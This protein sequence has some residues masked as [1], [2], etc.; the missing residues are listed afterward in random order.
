MPWALHTYI[1]KTHLIKEW[2]VSLSDLNN[3]NIITI[4]AGKYTSCFGF[5]EEEVF[6][7][8]DE[9]G[10]TN[11][12]EVKKWYDDFTIGNLTDIYNPLSIICFL[13]KKQLKTYWANMSS[14]GL[15]RMH[16]TIMISSR[17]FSLEMW[18]L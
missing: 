1:D 9:F 4:T 14:N 11:K 12:D 13:D 3:L 7:A 15:V 6:T 2:W 5:T 10:L 8:M 17:R 16:P 18:R